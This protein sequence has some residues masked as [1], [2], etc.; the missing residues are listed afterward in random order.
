MAVKTQ[1]EITPRVEQEKP[2]LTWVAKSRPFKKKNP[3]TMQVVVVLGVLIAMVLVFAGEWMLLAVLVALAFYYY[4]VSFIAPE[5]VEYQ[6]TNFGVRAFGKLFV[7]GEFSR[8]WWSEKW[9]TK[10]ISLEL[11]TGV[12]GRMFIPVDKV[13]PGEVEQIMNKFLLFDEPKETSM[14]KMSKWMVKKF[15][16]E[17]ND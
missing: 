6:L 3:Q 14:E 13:K 17:K 12:M 7:W 10:L 15:P 9:G 8:W 4:V 1:P 16:L 5:D 2:F 11:M